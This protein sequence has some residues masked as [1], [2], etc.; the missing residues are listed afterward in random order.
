L[1]QISAAIQAKF[2]LDCP[3]R[4]QCLSSS[5]RPQKRYLDARAVGRANALQRSLP[6]G[7]LRVVA[8]EVVH[9]EAHVLIVAFR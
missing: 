1:E 7:A 3:H 9:H 2:G 6:D 4:R 8:A 5:R